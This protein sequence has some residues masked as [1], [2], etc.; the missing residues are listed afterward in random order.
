[1]AYIHI[2]LLLQFRRLITLQMINCL[3]SS[4]KPWPN[5]THHTS[6]NR[7]QRLIEKVYPKRTIPRQSSIK[8]ITFQR[9]WHEA[10][11]F[12]APTE[13]YL[14]CWWYNRIGISLDHASFGFRQSP[15]HLESGF[16]LLV[17]SLSPFNSTPLKQ[18]ISWWRGDGSH[19]HNG[20]DRHIQ[21][22]KKPPR[23][24]GIKIKVITLIYNDCCYGEEEV[25]VYQWWLEFSVSMSS[26]WYS[27]EKWWWNTMESDAKLIAAKWRLYESFPYIIQHR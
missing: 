4:H 13:P 9:D 10:P 21:G 27:D 22:D 12:D 23:M 24:R 14:N 19:D 25:I 1:M 2:W 5:Y 20:G 7:R 8:A 17:S 15:H 18:H 3:N 16:K 26:E 11:Y 6:I